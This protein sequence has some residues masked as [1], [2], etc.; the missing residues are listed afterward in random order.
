MSGIVDT[1]K[2]FFGAGN[3]AA[4]RH[5]RYAC[6]C[7]ASLNMADKSGSRGRLEGRI[8]DVS[9]SGYL[10]VLD[11]PMAP[12]EFAPGDGNL[13][14]GNTSYP[15]KVHRLTFNGL[16]CEFKT[17]WTDQNLSVFLKKFGKR[18]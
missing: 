14:I 13:F 7:A 16:A 8:V 12:D 5:A 11:K 9:A 10:F 15:V 18:A 1:L 3:H 4:R 17:Y 2:N 6:D